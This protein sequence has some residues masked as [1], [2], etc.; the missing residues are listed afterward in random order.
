MA[1]ELIDEE[2]RPVGRRAANRAARAEFGAARR[3]GL[4]F[5]HARKLRL[6]AA[7]RNDAETDGDGQA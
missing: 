7:R 5:R 6:L 2:P 4:G 3:V 1:D